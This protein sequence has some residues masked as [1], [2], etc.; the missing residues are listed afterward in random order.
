MRMDS[1]E[2]TADE[3][4]QYRDEKQG[5]KQ[6]SDQFAGNRS[7]RGSGGHHDHSKDSEES[8]DHHPSEHAVRQARNWPTPFGSSQQPFR[9][10]RSR[11][12]CSS[13]PPWRKRGSGRSGSRR[14]SDIRCIVNHAES[15]DLVN[16]DPPSNSGANYNLLFKEKSE[17]HSYA[18]MICTY[19][20]LSTL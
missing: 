7:R 14:E 17:Q 4:C 13:G 9:A 6:D 10:I 20:V 16:L 19:L 3:R 18:Q 1:G 11:C 2:D 8:E 5:A 12:P 15:V